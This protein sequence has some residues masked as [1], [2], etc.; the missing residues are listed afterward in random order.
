MKTDQEGFS[1]E[2]I[3]FVQ[4][5]GGGDKYQ[6]TDLTFIKEERAKAEKIKCRE[7][8]LNE[9][10][11]LKEMTAKVIELEK[12]YEEEKSK[13]GS[14]GLSGVGPEFRTALMKMAFRKQKL[15]RDIDEWIKK[16]GV[17]KKNG[18]LSDIE[19]FIEINLAHIEQYKKEGSKGSDTSTLIAKLE[20]EN[21]LLH[22]IQDGKI[23]KETMDQS[24]PY[25]YD[26]EKH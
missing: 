9:D 15:D 19:K 11:E 8:F 20:R 5:Y 10:P 26:Y 16:V 14:R 2:D 23:Y 22:L 3:D 12:R 24:D 7:N 1:Q 13:E 17:G 6:D 4:K 25:H 21:E 18:E